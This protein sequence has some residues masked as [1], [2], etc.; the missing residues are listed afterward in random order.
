MAGGRQGSR[1]YTEM[2]FADGRPHD[3]FGKAAQYHLKKND[4]ARLITA[5]G[6]G[7]GDP[8]ARPV[9]AV[10]DDVKNGY[11]SIQQAE[12]DF[13]VVLVLNPKTLEVERVVR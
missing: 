4:V 6:G 7:Y 5:T 1:N 12:N 9:E 13:G 8:L 10:V 2:I 11:I 3:I